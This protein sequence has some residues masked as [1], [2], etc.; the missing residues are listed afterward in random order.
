MLI[1]ELTLGQK[2]QRG[3]AGSTRGILPRFAGAG[4]AASFA[5]FITCV[6]YIIL[7][8]IVACYLVN[9]G[10]LPWKDENYKE[11]RPAACK[12]RE[13]AAIP[14]AELYLYNNIVNLYNE[15]TCEP[16]KA[17]G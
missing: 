16:F 4:W 8:G 11:L 3:S 15:T 6:V 7:L 14:S 13:Y 17:D 10:S 12:E 5:S 1:L 9:S 2:M